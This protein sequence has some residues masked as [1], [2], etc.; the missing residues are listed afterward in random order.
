MSDARS[1]QVTLYHLIATENLMQDLFDTPEQMKPKTQERLYHVI[2]QLNQKYGNDSLRIG[3][4][5]RKRV[6]YTG[7]KI[8]FNRIPDWADFKE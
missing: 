6:P 7:A 2:D 1:V 5:P 4:L 8:A 3:E